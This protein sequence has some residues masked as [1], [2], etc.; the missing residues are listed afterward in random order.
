MTFNRPVVLFCTLLFVLI[1]LPAHAESGFPHHDV[2]VV[3]DQ[4]TGQL[5]VTDRLTISPTANLTVVLAD[6]LEI[7]R[8]DANGV[9]LSVDRVGR[10]WRISSANGPIDALTISAQ[11]TVPAMPPADQR[12]GVSGAA[13]DAWDGSYLPSY[14]AW[15]PD[16][17]AAHV[18]YRLKVRIDGSLRPVATGRILS[19]TDL[20]GA[21]EAVFAADYPTEAPSLFIGPY[22]VTERIVDGT[23]IRTYFHEEIAGSADHYITQSADYIRIFAEMIGAYPFDD[24]HVVSAPLPVGL[25]FPNMTYIGRTIVPLP[26]MRGRSLAHEVL[27]NWWGNGV[28]IDYATGNWSEGLTT[29]FADYGLA[30]RQGPDAA[31]EMRLGWLRDYAALPTS[32]DTPVSAFTSKTHQASQVI[33]Y[34]KT[35]HIFHMLRLEIGPAAFEQGIRAFWNDHRFKTAAWKDIQ[36]ALETASGRD[37]DWFFS[38]WVG[39][40]GAPELTLAETRVE[41]TGGKHTLH[42]TLRQKGP[43]YRLTVPIIV[44]TEGEAIHEQVRLSSAE[45]TF[46][47]ELESAPLRV[48]VDPDFDVFRRLLP[49]ESP[50]ILRDI[51]LARNVDATVLG[52]DEGFASA[53]RAL[54][55]RLSKNPTWVPKRAPTGPAIVIGNSADIVSYVRD[56]LESDIPEPVSESA[57]AAWTFRSPEGHPVLLIR[58]I[59]TAGIER[60]MRP[61]PHYGSRSYVTFEDGRATDKGVWKTTDSPLSRDLSAQKQ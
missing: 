37:L 46:S 17:G 41:Q 58:A 36:H 43:L 13:A 32:D 25:G 45:E 61:L 24:F 6:W 40:A 26:F 30:E 29:F 35:A 60:M 44:E 34:N 55:G 52:S 49:G 50:P 21:F 14:A 28:G 11:G 19:E 57:A 4:K 16:T 2:Q 5:G 3:F 7:D 10:H 33:G 22:T 51:T 15:I 8:A 47:I 56:H 59:D 53:A 31:R 12:R 20:D 48:R 23:R 42:V 38:Q 54:T 18:T 9:P 39:Q 1:G 27:H